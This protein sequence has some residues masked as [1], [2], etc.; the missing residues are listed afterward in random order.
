MR[1]LKKKK[2]RGNGLRNE[3]TLFTVPLVMINTSESQR[4]CSGT[5]LRKN[6]Y[7]PATHWTVMSV[8]CGCRPDRMNTVSVSQ[9]PSG[10]THC[11]VFGTQDFF[12]Q[13]RC[14]PSKGYLR[15]P[16]GPGSPIVTT[17]LHPTKRKLR[18]KNG[19]CPGVQVMR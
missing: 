10:P 15:E 14:V 18:R 7:V 11:L 16:G 6:K 9:L 1:N 2:T 13:N 8:V 4:L 17:F 19:F 5:S 3:I 12:S